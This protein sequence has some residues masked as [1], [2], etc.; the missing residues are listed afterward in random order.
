VGVPLLDKVTKSG[1]NPSTNEIVLAWRVVQ[2]GKALRLNSKMWIE[3][4]P[5]VFIGKVALINVFYFLT[6]DRLTVV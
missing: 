4:V 1:C 2:N 6:S 3:K 5:E